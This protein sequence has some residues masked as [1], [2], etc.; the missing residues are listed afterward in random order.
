MKNKNFSFMAGL[1]LG[2]LIG[3][4]LIFILGTNLQKKLPQKQESLRVI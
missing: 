4:V 2:G 1:V 3:A